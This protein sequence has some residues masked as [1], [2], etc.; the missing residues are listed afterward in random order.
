MEYESPQKKNKSKNKIP[1]TPFFYCLLFL[2]ISI[3]DSQF[4]SF[5][6]LKYSNNNKKN[7]HCPNKGVGRESIVISFLFFFEGKEGDHFCFNSYQDSSFN[8]H[9]KRKKKTIIHEKMFVRFLFS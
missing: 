9:L 8:D 2:W 6:A 3:E 4:N 5:F 1:N 7:K